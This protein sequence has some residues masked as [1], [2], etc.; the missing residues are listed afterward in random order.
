MEGQGGLVV[1]IFRFVVLHRTREFNEAMQKEIQSRSEA[2][3]Q[4]KRIVRIWFF[5]PSA[6][7]FRQKRNLRARLPDNRNTPSFALS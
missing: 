1:L 4:R 7:F 3:E 2:R 5:F 6:A